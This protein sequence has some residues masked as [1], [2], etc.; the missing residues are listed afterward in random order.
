MLPDTRR[1]QTCA[2]YI[3]R[4]EVPPT[5]GEK[6]ARRVADQVFQGTVAAAERVVMVADNV[7]FDEWQR[8][9]R[10][11]PYPLNRIVAD[12]REYGTV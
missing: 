5:C 4:L 8:E 2:V 10:F 9:W 6:W 12:T 7:D 11:G 1:G 3:D